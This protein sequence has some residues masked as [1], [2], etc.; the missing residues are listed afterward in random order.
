MSDNGA[1]PRDFIVLKNKFGEILRE[2]YNDDYENMGNYNSYNSYGPQWAEAGSS[3][4]RYFKNFATQGGINTPMIISGPGIKK[5]NEIHHGFTT[6]MDLAPTFYELAEVD[7]PK[8]YNEKPIYP[9]KGNSL[10]PFLSNKSKEIHADDYV[11]GLEHGGNAMIRKGKWKITNTTFPFNKDN[12]ELFDLS[13]DIGEQ[14]DLRKTDPKKY[15]EL[16]NEWDKFSKEIQLK[17]ATTSIEE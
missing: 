4:F 17:P 12:F 10:M 6:L 7:Y 16:L 9:L 13:T 8:K 15:A 5:E 11:F 14:N 1:A 2:Y 3:P